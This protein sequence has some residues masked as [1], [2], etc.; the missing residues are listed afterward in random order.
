[1]FGHSLGGSAA[2]TAMISDT[3]ILAGL[4][5]DGGILANATRLHGSDRIFINIGQPG[6]GE[7]DFTW[8]D[9][10]DASKGPYVELEVT[11][12][13]HSTFMDLA[14]VA[15]AVGF[16]KETAKGLEGWVGDVEW[17]RVGG[18][19]ERVVGAWG[20]WVFEGQVGGVL[21]GVDGEWREVVLVR[22]FEE[23]V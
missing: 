8:V 23:L 4:N 6:H 19:M 22:G 14:I 10:A 20:R 1:M 13:R 5:F 2:A 9:F 3:R 17:G 16:D 21:R 18:L 15:G 7:F 12:S 11:G